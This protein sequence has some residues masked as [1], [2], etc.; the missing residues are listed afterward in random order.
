M[1]S[2]DKLFDKLELLASIKGAGSAKAKADVIKTFNEEERDIVRWAL[3]PTVVYYIGKLP[4]YDSAGTREWNLGE[5][6]M[7]DQLAE[8][9]VTGSGALDGVESTMLQLSVK[10][11]ELLRRVILKDL[12]CNT[13]VTA[14]NKEFPGLIPEFPYMRCSLPA[15]AKMETWDWD[16][17][18]YSQLKAN[19]SFARL[20]IEAGLKLAVTV[21]TRQGNEY[22]PS[23]AIG[24]L[25]Q[26]ALQTLDRGT[27]THGELTVWHK[28]TNVCLP[29][30]E[31]NGMLNSLLD[32]G[33]LDEAYEVR[34]DVWDQIPL[35]NAVAGGK[36][37]VPYMQR[38]VGLRAQVEHDDPLPIRMIECRIVRSL[39]EAYQHYAEKLAQGLEGTVVKNPEGIWRDGDSKDQVKLKLEVDVDLKI[40]GFRPG[41][42]GKRTEFTFGSVLCRTSDDLLEVAVSGFKRDMEVYLNENRPHVLGT[43]MCVRAN[44]VS[45]PSESNE[46][47]SLYH[48][49][50][51]ELRKDK[52]VADTLQQ[53][54]DQFAAAIS[55][56]AQLEGEPA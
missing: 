43:I 45:V 29:R 46:L 35:S 51:V 1:V 44:E 42:I 4:T 39:T 13:G 52:A 47:H 33:A 24:R 54:L 28:L 16:G 27:E 23:A 25:Q 55:S 21:R 9:K 14:F 10:S 41:E 50:F 7:L 12:R 6:Y 48:P 18:V 22:P 19:G 56:V 5:L 36:Y 40:V 34:F 15:K 30:A 2:T 49:R 17:G 3:D 20:S 26:A 11:Q 31:G 32:G 53:V 37:D 8:R 38:L